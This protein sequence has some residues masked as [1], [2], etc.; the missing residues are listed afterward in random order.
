[1][2]AIVFDTESTGLTEPVL[3]EAAYIKVPDPNCLTPMGSFRSQFNPGKRIELGAMATDHIMDEDLVNCPP[4]SSFE[5]PHGT[6][7]IIGHNIVYDR[8]VLGHQTWLR[9]LGSR[10]EGRTLRVRRPDASGAENHFPSRLPGKTQS[11]AH[12]SQGDRRGACDSASG[13]PVL[14]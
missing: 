5:L 13:E 7:Y 1:M 8:K 3:I 6:Q 10:S 11:G 4:A 9:R 14:R 2:V 12:N